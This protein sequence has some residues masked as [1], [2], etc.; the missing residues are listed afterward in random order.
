MPTPS[1]VPV[2]ITS[3]G[4]SVTL[5]EM[6]S[7]SAGMSKIKR[8]VLLSWRSSPLTR[9]VTRRLPTSTSRVGVIGLGGSG[10]TALVTPAM[11]ALPIGVPKL[12]V[13]TVASGNVAAYVGS[14]D[15]AMM[16]SV[17]DIAGLN[18]ISRIV[19]ANAARAIAGMAR[20]EPGSARAW[21]V[22]LVRS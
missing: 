4:W 13:S 20:G 9:Q 7:I 12:V 1:G 5:R 16:Y 22:G 17:T 18:R 3:P 10:N 6:V 21:A 2:A 15:I 19:L 8:A 14:S 11:R